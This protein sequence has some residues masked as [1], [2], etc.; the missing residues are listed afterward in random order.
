M[1]VQIQK[2]VGGYEV[3]ILKE[4][5]LVAVGSYAYKDMMFD[6]IKQYMITNHSEILEYEVIIE[7]HTDGKIINEMQV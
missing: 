5:N 7:D 6:E 4:N 1:T 3:N 2:Q